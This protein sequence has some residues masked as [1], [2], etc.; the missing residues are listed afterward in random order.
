M[1]ATTIASRT[2]APVERANTPPKSALKKFRSMHFKKD[3]VQLITDAAPRLLSGSI[4][5]VL[6]ELSK[7]TFASISDNFLLAYQKYVTPVCQPL[8]MQALW[9]SPFD[10]LTSNCKKIDSSFISELISVFKEQQIA[11]P[12]LAIWKL[13]ELIPVITALAACSFV[14]AAAN[15]HISN[16]R[17]REIVK[18]TAGTAIM[19]FATTTALKAVGLYGAYRAAEFVRKEV[20]HR[21]RLYKELRNL[22]DAEEIRERRRQREAE[23]EQKKQSALQTVVAFI[24][25][26]KHRA[27]RQ[28][29][30]PP[31]ALKTAISEDEKEKGKSTKMPELSPSLSGRR[32]GFAVKNAEKV[33][34]PKH[35]DEVTAVDPE[36]EV[37]AKPAKPKV[38]KKKS[39]LHWIQKKSPLKVFFK[40]KKTDSAAA[41]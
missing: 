14:D 32:V 39:V 2:A 16:K 15:N 4:C 5:T 22:V 37:K 8:N 27:K 29:T 21:V 19:S 7:N 28:K 35:I 24:G 33:L 40:T 3:A 13:K 18:L 17:L 41:S 11:L 25:R 23:E 6:K 38:K 30:P 36:D 31:L 1:K 34:S 26:I 10:A 12:A 9:T 20:V